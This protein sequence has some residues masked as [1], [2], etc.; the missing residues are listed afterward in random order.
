MDE[1]KT[2]PW[3]VTNQQKY[4]PIN[5]KWEDEKKQNHTFQDTPK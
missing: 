5:K 2:I 3:T 1:T 4:T